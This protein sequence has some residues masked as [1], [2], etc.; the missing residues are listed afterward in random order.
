MEF[1]KAAEILGGHFGI[2]MDVENMPTDVADSVF[3][4]LTATGDW[5]YEQVDMAQWETDNEMP[6]GILS[7]FFAQFECSYEV[8][9][10][11]LRVIW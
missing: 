3:E 4:S 11:K 7:T 2:E 6:A 9:G 5:K 8:E 10:G 1:K